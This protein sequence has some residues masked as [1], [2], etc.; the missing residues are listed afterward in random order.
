MA[1]VSQH[2]LSSS[3]SMQTLDAPVMTELQVTAADLQAILLY[4]QS[5]SQAA[6][7]YDMPRMLCDELAAEVVRLNT[8]LACKESAFIGID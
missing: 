2:P 4:M 8:L 3:A 5:L 6:V 1:I 7:G